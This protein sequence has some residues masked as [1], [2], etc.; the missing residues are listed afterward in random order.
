MARFTFTGGGS[1][2]PG[3]QGPVGPQGDS[4]Y[5]I[6][7]ENGFE[8]TEQEWLDSLGGGGT[9]DLGDFTFTNNIATVQ[10]EQSM[11]LNATAYESLDVN[12]QLVLNPSDPSATL[13]A[14]GSPQI[15]NY[16]SYHWSS[17]TWTGEGSSSVLTID[18]ASYE[19]DY[20]L[21]NTW[22]PLNSSTNNTRITINGSQPGIFNGYNNSGANY[23]I[24]IDGLT[25]PE[26]PAVSELQ[27]LFN[28]VSK[29]LIGY[30]EG[31]M[32]V[33]AEDMDLY[34]LSDDDVYIKATGDD[35]HIE[36]KDDIRFIA[37]RSTVQEYNWRMDAQTGQFQLPGDGYISNPID[38]SGD[39]STPYNDT[40][41]LVPDDSIGSD[42]YIILDPTAPNH[43]HIRAGG[44]MDQSTADLILG[45][46]K[47]NVVVSDSARDVF[48]NTRPDMVINTYTNLSEVPGINFIVVN[49]ADIGIGYTVNVDG[50]DYLVDSVE[51]FDEGSKIVTASGASFTAGQP[52][53]FTYNPEYT[54]SWEFGSNGYLYGPAEGHLAVTGIYSGPDINALSINAHNSM[55]ISANGGDMNF[56]MDGGMY[57]GP[58][59]SGNQ[60]V[61][62]ED[63]DLVEDKTLPSGGTTGQVLTKVD[64]VDYN[65]TWTDVSDVLATATR[66]SPNFEATGLTFTGTGATYPTYNSYYVKIGKLVT[67]NIAVDLS[68]VTNFG[69]GQLKTAL[70]FLPIP[71]A[72]N[73]FSAWAW[74]DPTQPADELNGHVQLVADHLPNSQVLDLHWLKET[75]AEPKP[76]IESILS[77]GNPLTFTTASKIYINGT[78]ICQ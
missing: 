15:W 63:L 77:Q 31:E 56:Y 39:P 16:D 17:A 32:L 54:N 13:L 45:G 64:E 9:A 70:P 71:S 58:S 21:Q 73:H 27:F 52:Y 29:V 59:E 22:A 44:S 28:Y 68:T 55:T 1:G 23:T 40:I 8:G 46:E 69:T 66:W 72:A 36:A 11:I 30:D 3:P 51:P 7:V 78:Y 14:K 5:D 53:T 24:Y 76:V 42:Q 75:T 10:N 74:V 60:I 19:L 48:I 67:F 4:A 57:I 50:T 12:A 26:D 34:L 2:A 35:I 33:K 37:G 6:A 62:M 20:F 38:S 43:I 65:A 47:N 61:K 25:P 41:H 49:T 18:N